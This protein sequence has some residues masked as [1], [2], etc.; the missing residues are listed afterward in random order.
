MGLGFR[1][2]IL[3]FFLFILNSVWAQTFDYTNLSIDDGLPSDEVYDILQDDK[4]LIW[5]AT[6]AGVCRYDGYTFTI[7][8]PFPDYND[9]SVLK[10]FQDAGNTIWFTT[11]NQKFGFIQNDTLFFHHLN[12]EFEPYSHINNV[13]VDSL[14]QLWLS[15]YNGKLYRSDVHQQ[16][17]TQLAQ[18]THERFTLSYELHNNNWI[19]SFEGRKPDVLKTE[20]LEAELNVNGS[21]NEL[22][23]NRPLHNFYFSRYCKISDDEYLV[24]YAQYLFRIKN[25]KLV[26][27]RIMHSSKPIINI[28][29]DADNKVWISISDNGI[30]CYDLS[31]LKKPRF[32]LFMEQSISRVIMDHERNYWFSST[33][34]GLYFMPSIG[35]RILTSTFNKKIYSLA[36]V[37]N[38]I[39]YTQL[40]RG[41]SKID[42]NN[43]D[44]SAQKV[45]LPTSAYRE[46]SHVLSLDEH[47]VVNNT[48]YFFR[49]TTGRQ[50]VKPKHEN[51]TYIEHYGDSIKRKIIS[52]L[53][54]FE[55]GTFGITNKGDSLLLVGGKGFVL[56]YDLST[57]EIREINFKEKIKFTAL[58][59]SD[60]GTIWLGAVDGL[61][62]IQ[63]SRLKKWAYED[64]LFAGRIT[65][66]DNFNNALVI[67]T[68]NGLLFKR[69]EE[70]LKIDL[71]DGLSSEMIK[72]LY[73]VNDT[74]IWLGT[75]RGLAKINFQDF[76]TFSYDIST[77]S[78]LDGLPAH[79]VNDI[80]IVANTV[81]LATE[82]GV[83]QFH[84]EELNVSRIIPK[85][86]IEAFYV[87]DELRTNF[88]SSEFKSKENNIQI[89]FK[90]I[91]YV[92]QGKVVYRYLLK[93]LDKHEINTKG[94]IARYADLAPGNYTFQ[95]S[96]SYDGVNYSKPSEISF[97]IKKHIS[98]TLAFVII[99]WLVVAA[100]IVFLIVYLLSAQRRKDELK[101]N[102]LLAE[103]KALRMQINPHFFFNSLTSIQQYMLKNDRSMAQNSISE[104]AQLIRLV[105][106]NSK[107][108]FVALKNELELIKKYLEVE[109]RRFTDK[110][111]FEINIDQ[112]INT[113]KISIPPLLLQPIIEN[114][115]WHGLMPLEKGGKISIRFM[116]HDTENQLL[117]CEI[118]DNGIGRKK[119]TALNQS[120]S[121]FHKSTGLKNLDER[122]ELMNESYRTN[123]KIEFND[124]YPDQ[125]NTGTKVLFYIYYM[126]E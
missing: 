54:P 33:S 121:I 14:N 51:L 38:S 68:N 92:R 81:Y 13:F 30:A 82:N 35:F 2:F 114:G 120:R 66:I 10:L 41:C 90:A 20:Q 84:P 12:D 87:N 102:M 80:I 117:L 94:M 23:F 46:I 28:Y 4:G 125:E 17:L 122:I 29:K 42:L 104:F 85:A 93:G 89:D 74:V 110:L 25:N 97:T 95:V 8:K 60:T 39:Y 123:M 49:D 72:C 119:S 44:G 86:R 106:E 22:S 99:F 126:K 103:Q 69:N 16:N 113:Q 7:L 59:E 73:T 78:Y 124:L 112:E 100:F 48:K 101:R 47:L 105:L 50:L 1:A 11:F 91:A 98:Q 19:Y 67:G 107:S 5:I 57:H 96:A 62:S 88:Q 61:Y 118:I 3:V 58:A 83:V 109:K 52:E 27:S 6:S 75:D 36:A 45:A 15:A 108:N 77:I 63:N 116:L 79:S 53:E 56:R 71:Q 111:D 31:D 115:I 40:E 55:R 65:C 21:W 64:R 9:C 24:S 34:D 37:N 43:I 32:T 26:E 76:E 70:L 18:Q